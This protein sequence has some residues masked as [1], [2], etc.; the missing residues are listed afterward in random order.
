[1]PTSVPG[2][3]PR[4]AR[5]SGFTLIEVMVV[6]TL[7]AIA[8]A[9]V[10]LALRDP[11]RDQLEREAVRLAALLEMARAEARATGLPV[12]WDPGPAETGSTT[13]G[14]QFRFTG[15]PPR[16]GPAGEPPRPALPER[17]LDARVQA[18]V[19]G[20]SRVVLGPEPVL[21]PQRVELSLGEH[22]LEVASDGLAAFA[23]VGAPQAQQP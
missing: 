11:A 1:M 15:L 7:I 21:P 12:T 5:W 6:V 13:G 8:V 23:V 18:R 10:S 17:W 9:V 20:A 22:R 3:K 4:T 14:S 2:S 16:A 19:A